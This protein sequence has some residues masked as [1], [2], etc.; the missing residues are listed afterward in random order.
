MEFKNK[1]YKKEWQQKT[2]QGLPYDRGTYEPTPDGGWAVYDGAVN[3]M[4]EITRKGVIVCNGVEGDYKMSFLKAA[5]EI[6]GV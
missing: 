3:Y 1:Y 5:K 2:P 6:L 4:G